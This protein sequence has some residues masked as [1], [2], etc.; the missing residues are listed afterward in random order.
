LQNSRQWFVFAQ[1]HGTEIQLFC[2]PLGWKQSCPIDSDDDEEEDYGNSH[3][4]FYLTSKLVLPAGGTVLDIQFYGDDGKSSLSSGKD[5]GTGME[6]RQKLGFLY[7]GCSLDL[8]LTSYDS[9]M[10]QPVP[11]R[12]SILIAPSE[13]HE[14]CSFVLLPMGQ[15]ESFVEEDLANAYEQENIIYAKS[16]L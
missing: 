8:W 16:E 12:E 4:P 13:I 10:W 11:F 15:N 1:A 3:F 2:I 5:S 6:R 7:L 14:Q 9:L